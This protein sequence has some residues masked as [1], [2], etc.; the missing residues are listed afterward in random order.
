[1]AE[2]KWSAQR[3]CEHIMQLPKLRST[4]SGQPAR[5][6]IRKGIFNDL[7]GQSMRIVVHLAME[8]DVKGSR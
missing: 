2:R 8:S 1:M 6:Q 4:G 3:C 7:V 5:L